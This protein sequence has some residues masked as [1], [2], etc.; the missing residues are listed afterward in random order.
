ME[1]GIL[2]PQGSV[3]DP[4]EDGRFFAAL[5]EFN[6][7]RFFEAHEIFEE[8]WSEEV[9]DRRRVLQVLVQA[10]VG[11]HKQ[12][13]GVPNGARKLFNAALRN[14]AELPLDGFVVDLAR[15][16]DQLRADLAGGGLGAPRIETR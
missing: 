6:R 9:G 16:R 13:I 1:G 15:L 11:Y 14:L 7:G 5:E 2:E 4:F 3:S 10:A 12:R 8:L